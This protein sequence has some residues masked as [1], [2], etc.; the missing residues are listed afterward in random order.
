MRGKR[1]KD[2][3]RPFISNRSISRFSTSTKYLSK[4]CSN[5][6]SCFPD[7]SYTLL[8]LRTFLIFGSSL[9]VSL[10]HVATI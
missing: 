8:L 9:I 5:D 4:R 1:R 2:T 10:V 7:V 3:Y 6:S